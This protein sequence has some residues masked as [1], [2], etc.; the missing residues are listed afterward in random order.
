MYGRAMYGMKVSDGMI[1][2]SIVLEMDGLD[3]L[4]RMISKNRMDGMD[5]DD[6]ERWR[7]G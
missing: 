7:G 2:G 4:R 6:W 3:G 1:R 5:V